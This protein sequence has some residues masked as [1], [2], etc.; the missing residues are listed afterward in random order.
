MANYGLAF[1]VILPRVH[2]FVRVMFAVVAS[3]YLIGFAS[4]LIA[5]YPSAEQTGLRLLLRR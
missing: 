3:R 1:Y 2:L 5:R 4:F